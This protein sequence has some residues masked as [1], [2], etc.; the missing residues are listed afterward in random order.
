[1][2]FESMSTKE[3]ISYF[4][5]QFLSLNIHI[6][7]QSEYLTNIY[8]MFSNHNTV[9]LDKDKVHLILKSILCIC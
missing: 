3:D 4:V 6:I 9:S 1:M 8:L 5:Q 2:R 7:N